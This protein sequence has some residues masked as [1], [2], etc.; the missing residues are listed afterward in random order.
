M[1]PQDWRGGEISP[2]SPPP[3]LA[4]LLLI[5]TS[6]TSKTVVDMVL[7][8]W[9]WPKLTNSELKLQNMSLLC[10]K[11]DEQGMFQAINPTYSVQFSI[12]KTQ[13]VAQYP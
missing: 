10:N 6:C 11:T 13:A 9:K 4:S 3:P 8:N 7:V 12:I 1:G 5:T 2:L